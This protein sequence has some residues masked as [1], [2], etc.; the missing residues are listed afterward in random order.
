MGGGKVTLVGYEFGIL[1][2]TAGWCTA[3]GFMAGWMV[4]DAVYIA[5]RRVRRWLRGCRVG[6]LRTPREG[7]G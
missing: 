4:S 1:V 7:G 5:A 6:T 3:V 2:V